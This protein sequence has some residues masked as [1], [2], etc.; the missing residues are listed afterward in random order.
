MSPDQIQSQ[1]QA[2]QATILAG[3]TAF[4][5]IAAALIALVFSL[6]AGVKAKQRE[7]SEKQTATDAQANKTAQHVAENFGTLSALDKR[8]DA[9]SANLRQ[10]TA[11]V[12][13][14]AKAMPTA[15]PTVVVNSSPAD[16]LRGGTH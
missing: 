2:W 3:I 11:N 5:V 7:L 9:Q 4:G 16:P 12:T 13:E 15:P 14:L 6:L 10:Q 8:V 1:I